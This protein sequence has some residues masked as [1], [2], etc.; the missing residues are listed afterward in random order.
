MQQPSGCVSGQTGPGPGQG[1]LSPRQYIMPS[2]VGSY[3]AQ[4][5][6]SPSGSPDNSM[7]P[8]AMPHINR[9]R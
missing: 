7:F 4:L 5:F 1:C 8:L 2:E 3:R 9:H 6:N